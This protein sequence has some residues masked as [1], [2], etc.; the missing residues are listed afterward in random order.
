MFILQ[1][2]R[3]QEAIQ[4]KAEGNEYFRNQQFE[5]ALSKYTEALRTCPVCKFPDLRAVLYSNRAA[6]YIKLV[7]SVILIHV[8]N[9]SYITKQNFRVCLTMQYQIVLKALAMTMDF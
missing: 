7:K 5:N 2:T 9:I 6:T 3:H 8:I 4:L 1:E